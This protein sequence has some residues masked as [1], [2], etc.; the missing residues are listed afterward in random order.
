MPAGA[1]VDGM[2]TTAAPAPA[3]A[4]PPPTP[5]ALPSLLLASIGTALWTA[6]V[7]LVCVVALVF[8][9]WVGEPGANTG[10]GSALKA[11]A[12]V[13]LLGHGVALHLPGG[14]LSV[15]PLGLTVLLIALLFRAGRGLARDTGVHELRDVL[16]AGVALA[17]PYAVVAAAIATLVSG[18]AAAPAALGW[19]FVLAL[20]AGGGGLALGS[21]L[22]AE[23]WRAADP[24]ARAVL[25]GA[26][27]GLLA[28]A[29]TGAAL[30]ALSAAWHAPAILRSA[31]ASAAG[32]ALLGL[33]LLHLALAPLAMVWA[34]AYAVGTGFAVGTGT[35]VSPFAVHVGALPALPLLRA[36]PAAGGAHALV[37]AGPLAAGVLCGVLVAR[38]AAEARP[39]DAAAGAAIAA[40]LAGV[41]F[42]IL[43]WWCSGSAGPGRL[44]HAGPGAAAGLAAAAEL[45]LPGAVAAWWVARRRRSVPVDPVAE[46]VA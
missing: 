41:T 45:A 33:G 29:G 8:V 32:G 19:P 28:L 18:G 2:V 43:L 39:R 37:L 5:A 40:G 46:P 15:P 11:G 20:V 16:T 30:A 1:K 44:S 12:L 14:T 6:A 4:D 27:G 7:G 22:A 26:G 24:R 3:R 25:R 36:L 35:V 10:M 34:S 21:G 17:V 23:R 31:T 13:W 9:V 42:G 38:S